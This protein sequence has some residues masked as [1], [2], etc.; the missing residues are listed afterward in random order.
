MEEI[1]LVTSFT[2]TLYTW[3]SRFFHKSALFIFNALWFS[4]F[5]LYYFRLYGLYS[6]RDSTFLMYFY[7]ITSFFLGYVCMNVLWKQRKIYDIDVY[8]NY[9]R[10]IIYI[11]TFL[12]LFV[13]FQKSILAIPLWLSGGMDE[14]KTSS[15]MESSL[16][17]GV[18]DIFFV[19]IAKPMHVVLTLYA[20]V[21]LFQGERN[22]FLYTSVGLLIILGFI[23]T[24]SRFSVV[25]IILSSAAYV[26]L[27]TELGV[28]QFINKY[29]LLFVSVFCLCFLVLFNMALRGDL[30]DSLY[31]YL[32]GCMPCSDNAVLRL[33]ESMTYY[34][35]VTFNG[36][37]RVLNQVPSMLGITPGVRDILDVA[38]DYM[39]QFEETTY[40]GYG[41][42][43]NAFV[44]MFT[45][46][47]ADAGNF[48]VRL[49]S[50][51]FGGVTA[52]I[53]KRAFQNPTYSTCS[54]L[55]YIVIMIFNSMVRAQTF[56]V[57][58]VMAIFLI[59][60]I[61]PNN[62]IE[63]GLP[64]METNSEDE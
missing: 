12:T 62:K 57:P 36:V 25:E 32:C 19:Y 56:L 33:D 20:I 40:I 16:S 53:N 39:I 52:V 51:L 45:Y 44:S 7:G 22:K 42:R 37:L 14:V 24:G 61:I 43:Y 28:K 15:I 46:F 58:S 4:I 55:L 38:Y 5:F 60:L 59:I 27:F 35:V 26:F 34:G 64:V 18:W 50:F 47:Y 3:K 1:L 41:I 31:C 6:A 54:L 21:S 8:F 29:R 63:Y 17:L 49:L 13:Y 2:L 23:G 11:L 30:G 48:G 10:K 9:K